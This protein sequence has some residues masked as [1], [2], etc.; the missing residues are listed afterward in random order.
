[1]APLHTRLS[2]PEEGRSK[3][4]GSRT[5]GEQFMKCV[6]SWLE[7]QVS[8]CLITLLVVP[9]GAASATPPCQNF[10][11]SSTSVKAQ[12]ESDAASE[13]TGNAPLPPSPST[14]HT[15][16]SSSSSEQA[17]TQNPQTGS[18]QNSQTVQQ[19]GSA[20]VGTAAAPEMRPE[21]AP[22]SRPSGAAIAAAKQR[23]VRIFTIRTALVLGAAVAIGVVTAA[24]VGSPSKPH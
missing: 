14:V 1:M 16:A 7:R 22:S 20:P 6:K 15:A 19:N 8:F 11:D 23:R 13:Q 21:G 5:G 3:S 9:M 17:V 4:V 24:S 12:I 2:L 18:P 10:R